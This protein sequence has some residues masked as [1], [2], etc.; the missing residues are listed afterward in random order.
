MIELGHYVRLDRRRQRFGRDRELEQARD[1]EVAFDRQHL[2][3]TVFPQSA[4]QPAD[5]AVGAREP[6][7]ERGPR[8]IRV[9][10]REGGI[11]PPS[12]VPHD[13]RGD[14]DAPVDR[15]DPFDAR[16]VLGHE[17]PLRVRAGDHALDAHLV[18]VLDDV[19]DVVH[20]ARGSS[21]FRPDGEA[22]GREP[23][24]R[25]RFDIVRHPRER[26]DRDAP[27]ARVDADHHPFALGDRPQMPLVVDGQPAQPRDRCPQI[28]A[29]P[30]PTRT[31]AR[32]EE[33]GDREAD[34]NSHR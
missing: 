23:G 22:P 11:A 30:W 32:P 12:E 6:D 10:S 16:V 1:P 29:T 27:I 25:L 17:L 24:D 21:S 34:E 2:C 28:H 15:A 8:S 4:S 7:A 5:L 20:R 18:P 3:A 13:L 14:Q 33:A 26:E 19:D 31:T 9:P